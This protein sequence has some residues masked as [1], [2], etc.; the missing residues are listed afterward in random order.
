ML[1]PIQMTFEQIAQMSIQTLLYTNVCENN[2]NS[3]TNAELYWKR[4]KGINYVLIPI[5]FCNSSQKYIL[6]YF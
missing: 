5:E 4:K 3:I 6:K 2:F 1:N